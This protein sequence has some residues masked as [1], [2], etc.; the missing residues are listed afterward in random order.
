MLFHCQA[1]YYYADFALLVLLQICFGYDVPTFGDSS[2]KVH[3]LVVV[4]DFV[5]CS[6]RVGVAVG[7][8]Y[9]GLGTI[10][11]QVCRGENSPIR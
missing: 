9:R 4:P 2:S 6:F 10:A 5:I 7:S 3:G 8:I 11:L 1:S